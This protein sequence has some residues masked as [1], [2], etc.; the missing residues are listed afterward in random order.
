MKQSAVCLLVAG[1]AALALSAAPRA[2]SNDTNPHL[3]TARAA[4]AGSQD[5][6]DL[7]DNLCENRPMRVPGMVPRAQAPAPAPGGEGGGDAPRAPRAIPTREQY[8]AEPA[9]IFDNLY[10]LGSKQENAWAV[11]TS[12][13]IILI[14][15]L[16]AHATEDEIWNGLETLG[17]KR[18][19]VKILLLTHGHPDHTGGAKFLQDHIPGL[20]T[21]LTAA[22]WDMVLKN[23]MGPAP[24]PKRDLETTDGMKLTLGDVTIQVTVVPG[25]SPGNTALL[26]PVRE[27]TTRH[28]A[29]MWS[30][31][32]LQ[33]N[34][35]EYFKL[36]SDSAAR[37]REIAVKAGADVLIGG[38][39][40]RDGSNRKIPMLATRKPGDPH[41]YVIGTSGINSV[42]TVIS[43][44]AA[45]KRD[46]A[47][48]K[49]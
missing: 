34:T 3:A 4:V 45:Y 42:L 2:Q 40:H 28:L 20:R 17:L 11:T 12:A 33:Q 37:F 38:H 21:Y 22:D 30:G 13:G 18:T 32:G 27:G 49:K 8:H 36:Y 47:L 35:P 26:I 25:H 31:T 23:P 5:A 14:D 41:P 16:S 6:S 46:L 39:G 1:A 19:D 9:K 15:S 10:F 43:E 24:V 48:E 44:C 29:A 7:F